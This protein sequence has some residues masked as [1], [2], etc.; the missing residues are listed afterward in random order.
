MRVLIKMLVVF[1]RACNN[2]HR[3]RMAAGDGVQVRDDAGTQARSGRQ[4]MSNA[5][6]VLLLIARGASCAAVRHRELESVTAH[7]GYVRDRI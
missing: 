7:E 6:C 3:K 4:S 1:V 5:A 2:S